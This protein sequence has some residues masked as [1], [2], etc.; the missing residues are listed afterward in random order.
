MMEMMKIGRFKL[1]TTYGVSTYASLDMAV[2]C[3]SS[4][5]VGTHLKSVLDGITSSG[6]MLMARY[7]N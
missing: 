4:L 7:L 5:L 1:K 3:A 6:G 2:V